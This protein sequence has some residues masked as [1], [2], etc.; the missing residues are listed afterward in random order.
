[1]NGYMKFEIEFGVEELFTILI[2][3]INFLVVCTLNGMENKKQ[4]EIHFKLFVKTFIT[5]T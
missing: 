1:M 4:L 5:N 3:T 2:F